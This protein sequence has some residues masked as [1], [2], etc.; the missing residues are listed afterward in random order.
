MRQ[1]KLRREGTCLWGQMERGHG[2]KA[3]AEGL[4]LSGTQRGD[5]LQGTL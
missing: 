4:V 2:R 1:R 5:H 3:E